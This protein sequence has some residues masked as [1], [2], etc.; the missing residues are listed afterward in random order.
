[1]GHRDGADSA[2]VQVVAVAV[3]ESHS[4]GVKMARELD[5]REKIAQVAAE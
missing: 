1:M 2:L 4:R 5:V 3:A